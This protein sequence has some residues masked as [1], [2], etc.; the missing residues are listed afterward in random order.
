V[1]P[2]AWRE[3]LSERPESARVFK[4]VLLVVVVKYPE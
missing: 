4:V 2:A 1:L 3:E